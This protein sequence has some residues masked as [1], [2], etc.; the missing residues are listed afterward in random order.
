MFYFVYRACPESLSLEKGSGSKWR[1][2]QKAFFVK[3]GLLFIKKESC[4]LKEISLFSSE[5]GQQEGK[6]LSL[7]NLKNQI[8]DVVGPYL[9]K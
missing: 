4:R 1:L 2:T 7:R 3:F 9:K 5:F 6:M 8:Y